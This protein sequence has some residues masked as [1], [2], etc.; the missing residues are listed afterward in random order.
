MFFNRLPF[1]RKQAHRHRN[2]FRYWDGQT[3]RS[4]DPIQIMLAIHGHETFVPE[5]DG[6]LADEGDP[7][8]IQNLVAA[9][10]EAFGV[11]PLGELGLTDLEC[12]QLYV[13]F[14]SWIEEV[15]KKL[16][17][18]QILRQ[19]TAASTSSESSEPTTNDSSDCG[20]GDTEPQTDDQT[21]F[22]DR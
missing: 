5:R 3:Y 13:V 7:Q 22:A 19:T 6:P 10:R 8:A 4:G 1:F 11:R 14:S 17:S 2:I 18:S 9:V 21:E 16:G 15:K 12:C 20:S